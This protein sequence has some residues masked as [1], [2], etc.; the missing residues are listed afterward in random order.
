MGLIL[1]DGHGDPAVLSQGWLGP[2]RR[3]GAGL[4]AAENRAAEG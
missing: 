3:S 2:W 4:Q 1:F